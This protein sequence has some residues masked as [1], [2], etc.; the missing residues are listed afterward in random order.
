MNQV[1][2]TLLTC[3]FII[4]LSES[5]YAP[6]NESRINST[7]NSTAVINT[8]KDHTQTDLSILNKKPAQELSSTGNLTVAITEKT[9]G[10]SLL[11]STPTFASTNVTI[12]K[13]S[14]TA[15]TPPALTKSDLVSSD[16]QKIMNSTKLPISNISSTKIAI[17][18]QPQ[19][20][21]ANHDADDANASEHNEKKENP[22][23]EMGHE[24]EADKS[25]EALEEFEAK[26]EEA[27]K[28]EQDTIKKESS[29]DTKE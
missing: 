3:M 28:S 21:T 18:N 7:Q 23:A 8:S 13:S 4:L 1:I 14:E 15:P 5:I 6:G 16:L 20:T 11:P 24:T 17:N 9:P 22:Y 19:Y 26:K 12:H 2:K 29:G 25:K 10:F 27:E